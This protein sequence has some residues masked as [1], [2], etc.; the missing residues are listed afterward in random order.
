MKYFLMN[1]EI[2][3]PKVSQAHWKVAQPATQP[4]PTKELAFSN[5]RR[6]K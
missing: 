6:D 2:L 4:K 1:G 5:A 3:L